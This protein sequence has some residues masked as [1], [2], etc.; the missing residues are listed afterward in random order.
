MTPLLESR[1]LLDLRGD[2]N[3]HRTLV[4]GI[5]GS[6]LGTLARQYA[7]ET[8]GIVQ[9]FQG[10]ETALREFMAR[11]D[12]SREQKSEACRNHLFARAHGEKPPEQ[13]EAAA[14]AA[15][16][17]TGITRMDKLDQQLENEGKR[18]I[19]LCHPVE[20]A[21]AWALLDSWRDYV[22]RF[23]MLRIR[24]FL[25][26]ADVQ[27]ACRDQGA[28]GSK[29]YS[30]ALRHEWNPDELAKILAL[31]IAGDAPQHKNGTQLMALFSLPFVEERGKKHRVQ[32]WLCRKLAI[33]PGAWLAVA[34]QAKILAGGRKI[35]GAEWKKAL[36]EYRAG[37]AA[38]ARHAGEENA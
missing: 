34:K 17:H 3:C 30:G 16:D 6:G 38:M 21:M 4:T 33:T 20:S 12:V 1:A 23:R 2:P 31:R 22:R 19:L 5:P 28:D 8:A 11:A 29:L 27:E 9:A 10:P 24:I 26:D 37:Q 14:K 36:R 18:R 15:Y 25:R 35:R 7:Q 32:A 13:I